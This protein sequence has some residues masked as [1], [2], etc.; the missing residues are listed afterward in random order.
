M[1]ALSNFIF[2]DFKTPRLSL[3]VVGG[4]L[5]VDLLWFALTM[6]RS[7]HPRIGYRIFAAVAPLLFWSTYLAVSMIGGKMQWPAELW[8]GTLLWSA[9]VGAGIAAVLLPP[10][11][12]PTTWLDPA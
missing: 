3:I 2:T 10:A 8:T 7:A 5:V 9:I 1:P 11:N 12:T 4:G 6:I